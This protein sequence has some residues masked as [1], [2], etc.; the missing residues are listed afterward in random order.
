MNWVIAPPS[1]F[2]TAYTNIIR[3]QFPVKTSFD[4]IIQHGVGGGINIMEVVQ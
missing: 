1:H 4:T 2:Y 3:L